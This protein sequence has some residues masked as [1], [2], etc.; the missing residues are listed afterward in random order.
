MRLQDKVAIVTGSGSGFGEGI[1]RRF[2]EEGA[3]VV[4]NDINAA[5]GER[6][7]NAIIAN[8]GKA[9]FIAADVTKRA[10]VAAMIRQTVARFGG[11]DIM[12][13]NAGVTHRN[14]SLL[15]VTDD[16]FDRIYAVNVKAIYLAA[17]EAVPEFIRRGGGVFLNTSSTAALRPRPGLVFYNGSKG[18][19]NTITKGMAA[20][21]APHKIR[22]NALC[23]VLGATGLTSD[24]I[25]GDSEELIAKFVATV[26]LGRMSTP[27]DI[28][29]AAL[30]LCSDE[31]QF[32]TGVCLEVD[33]GRCI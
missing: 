18:A 8:G 30:F 12:V 25:G 13:N 14:K 24:F 3:C 10:D 33:G 19:A 23:P 32:L 9:I 20:E 15:E 26:P 17:Q 4:V 5:N 1:A 2:A 29:N 11:L 21:L 31:A 16:E 28:A 6:V 22:V 27:L 7:A